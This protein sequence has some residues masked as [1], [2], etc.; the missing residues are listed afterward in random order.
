MI[1]DETLASILLP[2]LELTPVEPH[3]YTLA[4]DA[5]C[6]NEYDRIGVFYDLIMGNSVYNRVMWGYSISSFGI[7][8]PKVLSKPS[9]GWVLD[10]GCGS[11]VFTAKVYASVSDRPVILM[12]QSIAMLRKARARMVQLCGEF[13]PNMAFLHGDA[14]RLPFKTDVFGSVICLNLLHVLDDV[15]AFL[16]GLNRVLVSGGTSAFTTLVLNNRFGDFYMRFLGGKGLII[17]RS[18]DDV[19][20]AFDDLAWQVA[21]QLDGN[22]LFLQNGV[23]MACIGRESEAA[24]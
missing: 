7:V 18:T 17:P 3:I 23:R 11:L 2:G 12:D 21:H 1:D 4:S 20:E 15:H 24:E 13:P 5:E 9:E 19:L 14:L 6:G 8:C 10:V 22:M 16:R